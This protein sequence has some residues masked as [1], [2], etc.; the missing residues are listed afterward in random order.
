MPTDLDT[1]DVRILEVIQHDA[2]LAIADIAE[3]VSSSNTVV[4][5][6]IQKLEESGVIRQ[7]A[8]ILDYRKVGFD[9]MVIA[10]VKMARHNGGALGTFVDAIKKLP[11]VIECHT[12]MGHVDFLLKIVV[13]SIDDYQQ[14]VWSKLSQIEG[15]Q[16]ISSAI[17]MSQSINTTVLPIAHINDGRASTTESLKPRGRR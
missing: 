13:P 16:E 11:A 5:R 12:L 10:M 4:W 14:F 9:I 15:V 1:L 8:A 2:T 17:S 6:R 3:R 7:R